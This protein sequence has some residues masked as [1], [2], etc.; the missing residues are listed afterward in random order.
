LVSA[1][2]PPTDFEKYDRKTGTEELGEVKEKVHI[3]FVGR[4]L[5]L[6]EFRKPAL[7]VAGNAA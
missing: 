7:D 3:Y 4:H 2:P 6:E 1:C 5:H